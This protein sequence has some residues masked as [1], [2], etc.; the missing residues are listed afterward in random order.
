MTFYPTHCTFQDQE[1]GKMN[2][3]AK[4]QNGLYYL[5]TS[6]VLF[7]SFLSKH[8]LVNKE[9][10]WLYHRRFG[11]PSF[12]TLKI[13]FPSLFRKLD[14]KSFHCDVYKLAKHKHSTFL[15][16]NDKKSSKPFHLTHSDIRGPSFVPNISKARWFVS[17]IDDCTRV[18]WIF[19]LK[20]KSYVSF[21]L[22][23]F[24]N[25]IKNQFGVTI[26]RFWSDNARYHFNQVLTLH[27]QLERIIHKSSC[28]NTPQQNELLRGKMVTFFIQQEL[29]C[30]KTCH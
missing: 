26:K 27:F 13:L 6:S 1:L 10:I 12:R 4:E 3:L 25:M 29:F 28:V 18:S 7:V 23:N 19:L 24:H 16:N 9:K 21:V 2:G 17:F 11:Y 22:Q 14:V 30:F 8:Y 15:T 20:H 5:E